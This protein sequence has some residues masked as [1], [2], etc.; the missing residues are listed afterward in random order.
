MNAGPAAARRRRGADG[1]AES[2]VRLMN[3][4]WMRRRSLARN[5]SITTDDI[6]PPR[7]RPEHPAIRARVHRCRAA[8][9]PDPTANSSCVNGENP[10]VE[11]NR[12]PGNRQLVARALQ[13]LFRAYMDPTK[14]TFVGSQ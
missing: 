13:Q 2:T 3:S 14:A 5:A 10:I 12:M 4:N 6:I 11:G 1:F 7:G 9:E 8:H